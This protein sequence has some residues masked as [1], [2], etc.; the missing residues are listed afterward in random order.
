MGTSAVRQKPPPVPDV[1]V[2]VEDLADIRRPS[3]DQSGGSG[4]QG[5][6]GGSDMA[7]AMQALG[8]GVAPQ[9]GE[10][11]S[12]KQRQP[13]YREVLKVS[14]PLGAEAFRKDGCIGTQEQQLRM[15]GY[16]AFL[17]P[18]FERFQDTI[19]SAEAC[20]SEQGP[21]PQFLLFEGQP[22]TG[23]TKHAVAFAKAMGLALLYVTPDVAQKP[24][25][26][27][28]VHADLEKRRDAVLFFDE[29][30]TFTTNSEKWCSQFR[31]FLD[32]VLSP[33]DARVIVLGT[34]NAPEKIAP[35]ILHRSDRI[36]FDRPEAVHLKSMWQMY[37]Q[38]LKDDEVQQLADSSSAGGLTGRDVRQ[39]ADFAERQTTISFLNRQG[40]GGGYAHGMALA[41]CPGPAADLYQQC[42][43]RRSRD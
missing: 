5:A 6:D 7:S 29:L 10:G 36:G 18:D 38:H 9:Q 42:I 43:R 11:A 26:F 4:Q 31:Q 41:G 20:I 3:P 27:N 17:T 33:S 23:K 30:D 1:A 28:Q 12:A 25:W 24:G 16:Y 34:T 35:D 37:A 8:L 40:H 32:G 14:Q 2:Q 21:A 19:R 22:G 39:C 15:L 13:P